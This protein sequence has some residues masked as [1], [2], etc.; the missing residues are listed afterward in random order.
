MANLDSN[1]LRPLCPVHYKAMAGPDIDNTESAAVGGPESIGVRHWECSEGGCPQNYSRDLGY[2]I[3]GRNEDHWVG[4][5]SS[6]IWISRSATQVICG[7]HRD[8]MFLQSVDVR[9]NLEN[10]RCPRKTC[11][12]TMKILAGSPP[13]YWLG[14]GYF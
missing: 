6:S 3:I 4:T 1:Y 2:F 5:G 13:A 7:E 14:E 8:S 9:A 10:F 12:H 11:Q